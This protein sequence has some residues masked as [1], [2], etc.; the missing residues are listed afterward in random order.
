MRWYNVRTTF[1]SVKA[2]NALKGSLIL[3][4]KGEPLEN[5]KHQEII[6]TYLS[7]ETKALLTSGSVDLN[8]TKNNDGYCL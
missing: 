7:D 3:F 6:E 5:T 8:D 4:S 2:H 1:N